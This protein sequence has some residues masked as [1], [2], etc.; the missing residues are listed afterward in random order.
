MNEQVKTGQTL[1]LSHW[2]TPGA[3]LCG[4]LLWPRPKQVCVTLLGHT[5]LLRTDWCW[6]MIFLCFSRGLSL[7]LCDLP[8]GWH[9][10]MTTMTMHVTDLWHH[11]GLIYR[12]LCCSMHL[13]QEPKNTFF[14]LLFLNFLN[15]R[16]EVWLLKETKLLEIKTLV[17]RIGN[18]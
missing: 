15:K 11:K 16:L 5:N 8:D 3:L 4:W 18:M 9:H 1:P 12:T 14:F 7:G 6:T 10:K 17:N 13:T 2:P